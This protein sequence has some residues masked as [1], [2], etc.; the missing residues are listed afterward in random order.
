MKKIYFIIILIFHPSVWSDEYSQKITTYLK[1]YPNDLSIIANAGVHYYRKKMWRKAIYY[2][3]AQNMNRYN[4]YSSIMYFQA[5]SYLHLKDHKYAYKLFKQ[6]RAIGLPDSLDK[7]AKKYIKYFASIYRSSENKKNAKKINTIVLPNQITPYAGKITYSDKASK[8]TGEILGVYYKHLRKQS[9]LELGI[10]KLTINFNKDLNIDNYTQE[11]GIATF[12]FLNKTYQHKFR[13]LFHM[14]KVDSSS[15]FS[16]MSFGSSYN[17]YFFNYTNIGVELSISKF[18]GNDNS[19][20]VI[21]N[22]IT[23]HITYPII[24][25]IYL[26]SKYNYASNSYNGSNIISTKGNNSSPS[27]LELGG[28]FYFKYLTLDAKY[29]FGKES[30]LLKN[31]GFIIQNSTDIIKKISSLTATAII[32]KRITLTAKWSQKKYKQEGNDELFTSNTNIIFT[33]IFF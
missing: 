31:D 10:E 11:D 9:I 18:S 13:A 19:N 7:K 8:D 2:F 17:Y 14:N 15:A 23:S 22:Q 1:K 5:K 24:N 4:N 21:S 29:T 12:A 20:D 16:A 32:S 33:N 30:F 27:S 6:A 3:S 28:T 25:W 26:S